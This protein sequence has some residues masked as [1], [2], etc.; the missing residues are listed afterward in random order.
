MA[1]RDRT[2]KSRSARTARVGRLVAGQGARIAGGR[3]LDRVRSED[4]RDRAQAERITKVVEQIVV[5]LGQMK[6]AAMKVGQVLSTIDFP[7]M[8]E[9]DRER[10]KDQLANLRDN[11]PRVPF[12]SS[13]S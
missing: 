5:Q 11:A 1:D 10:I 3:A 6:G 8:R 4:A 12:E 2:P 9:E 13:R 7:G